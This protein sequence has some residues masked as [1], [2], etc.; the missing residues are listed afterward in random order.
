MINALNLIIALSSVPGSLAPEAP[1]Q[2]TSALYDFDHKVYYRQQQLGKGHF[3]LA[4][5][6]DDYAHFEKQSV[7]LLRQAQR[8]CN[9]KPFTLKVTKGVQGYEALPTH[10]RAYQEDLTAEI[11]CE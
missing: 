5:R 1:H 2:T 11:T 4:V 7:F 10:P 9:E 6:A 8:L 3:M